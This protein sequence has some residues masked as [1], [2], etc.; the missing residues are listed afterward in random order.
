MISL[1]DPLLVLWETINLDIEADVS[2]M[3]P[4]SRKWIL[5]EPK[6]PLCRLN[7]RAG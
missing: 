5:E 7:D 6:R 2:P 3:H 1:K 4:M